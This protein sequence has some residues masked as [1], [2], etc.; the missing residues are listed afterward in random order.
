MYE[1]M[2]RISLVPIWA[3]VL[4]FTTRAPDFVHR[5]AAKAQ[6]AAAN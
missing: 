2:A 6:A 5:L 3:K 4:D 1:R